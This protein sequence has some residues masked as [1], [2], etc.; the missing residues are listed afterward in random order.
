MSSSSSSSRSTYTGGCF[1]L[2]FNFVVGS[3]AS[4]YLVAQYF[5]ENIRLGT[6]L[7]LGLVAGSQAI[8]I[9]LVTWILRGAGI[10]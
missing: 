9:T 5:G 10:L 3:M 1:V 8:A 7:L 2:L 4:H 6:S